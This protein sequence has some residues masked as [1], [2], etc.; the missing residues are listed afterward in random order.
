MNH[1]ELEMVAD[2]MGHSVNIHT[3]VYK[4]Q[5][6]LIERS[7]VAMVLS[8]IEAGSLERHHNPLS[9]EA[10]NMS[11]MGKSI[12]VLV[13]RNFVCSLIGCK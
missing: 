4:L 3:S 1:S 5:Q 11:D 6:N 8:A 10:V 2:H 9:L 13:P 7:K 12:E